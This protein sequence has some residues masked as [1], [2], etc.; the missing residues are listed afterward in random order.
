MFALQEIDREDIKEYLVKTIK[1]ELAP[2]HIVKINMWEDVVGPEDEPAY[3]V[4]I[5]FD[6]ERPGAKKMGSLYQTV[7][8]HFWDIKEEHT[9]MFYI[10]RPEDEEWIYNSP[11]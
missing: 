4:D 10:L 3:R 1:K 2:T 5:V 9:P 6:G 11:D 7:Y 8:A